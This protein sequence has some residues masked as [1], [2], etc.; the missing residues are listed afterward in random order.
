MRPLVPDLKVENVFPQGF[1]EPKGKRGGAET[2]PRQY[3]SFLISSLQKAEDGQRLEPRQ[4]SD[5]QRDIPLRISCK[6][7]VVALDFG[8]GPDALLV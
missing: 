3:A 5:L 2:Q 6:K 7:H 8:M 1:R 4:G